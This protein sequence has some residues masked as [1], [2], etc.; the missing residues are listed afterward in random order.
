MPQKRKAVEEKF[1]IRA[2]D[3]EDVKQFLMKHGH[4]LLKNIRPKL[5]DP[6]YRNLKKFLISEDT[7]KLA[8]KACKVI[9]KA[10]KEARPK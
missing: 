10:L 8:R 4:E 5:K 3:P 2:I 1:S 7:I 6:E 9:E